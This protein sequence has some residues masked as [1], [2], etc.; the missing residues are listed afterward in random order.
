ME[1]R[2]EGLSIEEVR[3][4]IHPD[5]IALV[6]A[7]AEETLLSEQP[8][9]MV[10]RYRHRD[11]SYRYVMTR[12]VIERSASGEPL[13]FV[14]VA[15]DVT[16]AVEHRRQA[17]ALARRLEAASRAAGIGLWTTSGDPPETDWNAQMYAIFDRFT[18]P[19]VPAFSEWLRQCVHAD[20]R[21]RVGR[22]TYAYLANG[23]G[24]SELE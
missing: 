1:P 21:E 15:L 6:I 13:A 10:V 7:K 8:T 12:R 2:P 14:G 20:D 11:G 3:A 18:P 23:D 9:D 24:L 4:L 22:D 19:V 5:D 17:D 16:E